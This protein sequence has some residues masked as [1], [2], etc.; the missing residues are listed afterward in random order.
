MQ[1]NANDFKWDAQ[2]GMSTALSWEVRL[3]SNFAHNLT[4]RS[5]SFLVFFGKEFKQKYRCPPFGQMGYVT[6]WI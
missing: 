1:C 4:T 6:K 5:A 3:V 2:N